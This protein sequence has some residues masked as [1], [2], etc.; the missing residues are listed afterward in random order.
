MSFKI[1]WNGISGNARKPSCKIYLGTRSNRPFFRTSASRWSSVAKIPPTPYVNIGF[2]SQVK[3]WNFF[4]PKIFSMGL[5]G[6]ARKPSFEIYLRTRSNRP[7]LSSPVAWRSS[8]DE[9]HATPYVN[10][11]F[12]SQVKFWNFFEFKFFSMGLRG[13][14]RKPSFKIYLRTRSNRLFFRSSASRR[15][16]AGHNPFGRSVNILLD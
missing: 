3:F 2:D 13:N 16:Y 8:V 12:D 15:S 7:F 1:F 4:D 5:G 9:T 14:A 6:N 10:I 11:G